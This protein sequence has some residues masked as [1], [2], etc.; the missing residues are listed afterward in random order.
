MFYPAW[1]SF[2]YLISK[3]KERFIS[4]IG[5]ISVLGVAVGVATLIVVLAVM[6]GFDNE[7]REKIVGA[8]SHIMV[9]AGLPIEDYE[10]LAA[11]AQKVKGVSSVSPYVGGQVFL[12]HQDRIVNLNLRGIDPKLEPSVSKMKDYLIKGDLDLAG[13]SIVVGRELARIFALDIGD[14]LSVITA[15]DNRMVDLKVSGIFNSGMYDYDMNLG[16]VNLKMAQDI[17]S[18]GDAVTGLGIKTTNLYKAGAISASLKKQLGPDYS[19]RSWIEINKNFFAALKLEKIT[20]FIILTLIVIVASFNIVA[21]LSVLVTHKTKDIGILRSIGATASQIKRIFRLE[22]LFIGLGG[23][24]LGSFLGIAICLILKRYQFIKLPEDIYY[25]QYL[26][27]SIDLKDIATV[28][29]V[30]LVITYLST[31]FPANKAASLKPVEALRY[32]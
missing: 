28:V 25:I 22:G 1:I 27:V 5:L 18:L 30:A 7:L 26:P 23:T 17:F 14:S 24:V 13:D 6:T 8:H 2:R 32:E 19:V 15:L 4:F 16:L 20:M 11:E 3:D 21:T 31:L 12:Y 9:E 29:L 10:A